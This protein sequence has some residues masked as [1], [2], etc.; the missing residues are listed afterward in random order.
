MQAQP[1][2]TAPV[3]AAPTKPVTT[4]LP[5]DLT[6]YQRV[7]LRARVP[8]LV[9]RVLVDRGS[10]V[11]Q[12]DLLVELSAP[13]MKTQIAEAESRARS[14]DAQRVEAMA[15]SVAAVS[16]L[17]RLKVA[18]ATPGAVAKNDLIQAEQEVES[19]RAVADAMQRSADAARTQAKALTELT[20]YLRIT[21]PFPGIVT[22]RLT[23]PGALAGPSGQELIEL[24]EV[25]RLR[26]V[27][28]VPEAYAG[29]LPMKQ[30]VKFTTPAFPGEVFTGVVA[31]KSSSVDVKSR[32]MLVEADVANR[33]LRLAPGMFAEVQWPAASG[34]QAFLVPAAA[35]VTTTERVFVIRVN[36]GKA[37]YV[38]VTKLH[39]E[40]DKQAVRGDL[41]VGDRVVARGTDEIREGAAVR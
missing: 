17:E 4:K 10:M 28:P 5:A 31:R 19:L 39:R 34:A 23:D 30:S 33:G 36:G 21:A 32:T 37:E 1:I 12:G 8:A 35:V 29:S 22:S 20:G 26:L 3:E 14:L 40:G 24:A 7:L 18:S 27:V 2:P 9:E 25:A 6:A 41:A 11:K 13:E 38:A 15:R 16:Q